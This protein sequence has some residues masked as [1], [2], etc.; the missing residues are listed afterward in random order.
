MMDKFINEKANEMVE[1]LRTKMRDRGVYLTPE[2]EYYVRIGMGYGLS[3]AALGLGN[4]PVNVTLVEE[5]GK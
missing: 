5:M 4:L 3:L 2:A 1:D